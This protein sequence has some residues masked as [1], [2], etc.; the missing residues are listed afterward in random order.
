[1]MVMLMAMNIVDEHFDFSFKDVPRIFKKRVKAQLE[2]MGHP[3]LADEKIVNYT[4]KG[5]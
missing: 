3:E 1:M 5:E 2:L 4:P